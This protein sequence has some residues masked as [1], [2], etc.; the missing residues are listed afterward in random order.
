[1]FYTVT[2]TFILIVC[3][4]QPYVL[5]SDTDISS[6]SADIPPYVQY[7][8][9]DI[10]VGWL[11]ISLPMFYTVT[12]TLI[13]IANSTPFV[14]YSETDIYVYCLRHHPQCS[15]Q[16]RWHSSWLSADITPMFCIVTLTY[17]NYLQIS[18]LMFCTVT[19]TFMLVDC[20]YH[21]L[22]SIQWH[23]H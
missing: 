7:I 16:W 13:L 18:P 15:I 5:Y 12:L 1:M 6:L 3:R 17:V 9:T 22:C 20:R 19:L 14:L 11:Q 10:H 2:L 8:D 21:S 4:Y 23:W